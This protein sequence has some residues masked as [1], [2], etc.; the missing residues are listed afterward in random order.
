M[1]AI[2]I[3]I[4]TTQLEKSKIATD[5][6]NVRSWYAEEVAAYLTNEGTDALPTTY[7]GVA[8]KAKGADVA[9]SGT[10]ANWK[11]EYTNDA[12]DGLTLPGTGS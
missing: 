6:A 3:P 2:A 8:L 12:G 7:G 4:F 11:V 10:G 1:V 9:I 5:K